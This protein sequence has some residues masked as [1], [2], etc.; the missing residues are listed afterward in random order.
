MKFPAKIEYAYKAVLELA[1]RYNNQ[2]PIRLGVIAKSQNVPKEFLVQLLIQLKRSGLV[3]STR[4]VV[5]G[6]YLTRQPSQISLVEVF[7]AIDDSLVE[8][9]KVSRS[10]KQSEADKVILAILDN[11]NKETVS[12]LEA[13]TFDKLISQVKKEQLTYNI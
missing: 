4:G 7:R 1:L 11:I 5:G 3:N 9:P 10:V 2:Q 12:R 8:T 6:Y 13:I